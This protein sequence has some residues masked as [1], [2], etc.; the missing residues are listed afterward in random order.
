MKTIKDFTAMNDEQLNNELLACKKEQ[1]NLRLKQ[2]TGQLEDT[3]QFK[4]IRRAVAQISALLAERV[5]NS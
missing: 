5:K 2:S 3:S 1:F 4:K